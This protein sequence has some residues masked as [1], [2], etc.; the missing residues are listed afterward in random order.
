MTHDFGE[1]VIEIEHHLRQIA[2]TVRRRGRMLLEDSGITPPQFE[3]LI[4]LNHTGDLTIG[5]LSNRLFLAY[6]TTTDLVDRLE[7]AG[8][9]VRQRDADDR[10]VVR[11]CLLPPGREIFEKVLD[12]RRTYLASVVSSLDVTTRKDI[13]SVLELLDTRM[14]DRT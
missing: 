10:R 1:Y 2:T 5:D 8:L 11:V 6:S 14:S 9:V 3:A 4:I 12:A 7:R 13:L